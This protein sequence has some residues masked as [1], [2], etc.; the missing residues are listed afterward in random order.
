MTKQENNELPFTQFESE[1]L[2]VSHLIKYVLYLQAKSNIF[3][4][5]CTR[6]N[7]VTGETDIE[8]FDRAI[9]ET[10]RV[11]GELDLDTKERQKKKE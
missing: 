10:E 6:L 4:S 1:V 7:K 3:N 8:F 9:S 2:Q 5:V 11:L